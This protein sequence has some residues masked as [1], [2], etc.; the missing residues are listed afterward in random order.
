MFPFEEYI[1]KII[2]LSPDCIILV[3]LD[4]VILYANPAAYKLLEYDANEL[5]GRHFTDVAPLELFQGT[6]LAHLIEK[7]SVNGLFTNY[8]SN[9]GKK[10][11]V[12]LTGAPIIDETGSLVALILYARNIREIQDI[13]TALDVSRSLNDSVV[14]SV[15]T[16]LVALDDKMQVLFHN[17]SFFNLVKGVNL[18]GRSFQSIFS[19]LQLLYALTNSIAESKEIRS[20]E[21]THPTICG[22]ATNLILSVS[23]VPFRIDKEKRHDPLSSMARLEMNIQTLVVIDD[24]TEQKRASELEDQRKTLQKTLSSLEK[25]FGVVGHELRTPLAGIR[26]ASEYLIMIQDQFSSEALP[27]VRSIHKEILNMGQVVNDLLEVARLNSGT[28]KWT[29]GEVRLAEICEKAICAIGALVDED[30]VKLILDI[31]DPALTMSGDENALYRLLINLL[32]NAHKHTS[33]G[34]ITISLNSA[35]EERASW[36]ILRIADTGCG[37]SPVIADKLGEE[38]ALN[39]GVVG[40]NYIRGSGLG[41]SICKGIASTHGGKIFAK[42]AVGAG[43]EITIYLRQDLAEPLSNK[44]KTDKLEMSL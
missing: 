20:I 34:S 23:I 37:I 15:P 24:I 18:K 17:P 11:P 32:N 5:Q 26:A 2:G 7:G 12:S 39:S 35:C 10:I 14:N 3:S 4:G 6:S 44:E 9:A 8:L 36:I 33:S 43:T 30:K 28:A 41:L 29:W 38:F 21:L 1:G 25:I 42:S 13:L 19:S 40:D 31:K 16:S 27:F 22:E